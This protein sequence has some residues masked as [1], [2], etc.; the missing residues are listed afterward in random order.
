MKAVYTTRD[1]HFELTCAPCRYNH[2]DCLGKVHV[3]PGGVIP[4]GQY[5]CE[6]QGRVARKQDA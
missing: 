4:A 1:P 2:G 6:R 3:A 5:R